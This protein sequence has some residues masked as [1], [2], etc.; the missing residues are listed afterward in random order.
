MT[1]NSNAGSSQTKDNSV[2]KVISSIP[3]TAALD[4]SQP[5][6]GA[7]GIFGNSAPNGRFTT[8]T[9]GSTP[10]TSFRAIETA[11]AAS[12]AITS[13]VSNADKPFRSTEVS[14]SNQALSRQ[15]IPL[16]AC[17]SEE[18]HRISLKWAEELQAF[19]SGTSF[20]AACEGHDACYGTAGVKG[21]KKYC[22]T[23]FEKIATAICEA[24][25]N[26]RN[27]L[28]VRKVRTS[29]CLKY[30]DIYLAFLRG[31]GKSA[32]CDAQG[33]CAKCAKEF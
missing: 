4:K 12:R 16:T 18:W 23:Q 32:F 20:D 14:P 15:Q 10:Q 29:V 7:N 19:T 2:S 17:G 27:S 13:T 26:P 6:N 8:E 11:P 3:N 25:N 5:S 21:G 30:K 22:D 33:T 9:A 24:E 1:N 28:V 31:F